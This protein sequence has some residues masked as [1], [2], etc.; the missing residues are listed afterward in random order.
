[1]AA[2][3]GTGAVGPGA[4]GPARPDWDRDGSDWPHRPASRFIE[5]GGLRWHVQVFGEDRDR[6]TVLLLHGTGAST[7][8]WRGL[9]PRLAEHL[10]VVAPDLPGHAFSAM[11]PGDG[12]SLPGMA[13]SVAALLAALGAAP[14]LVVGHSAGAAIGA[15]LILD[16]PGRGVRGLVA[17]NPAFLPFEGL[18]GRVFSPAARW[19]GR[20][21]GTP[22]LL[23]RAGALPQVLDGL[24]RGTGSSIG[25]DGRR[26]YGRLVAAPG[27]VAGALGMMARWDLAPLARDLPRLPCPLLAI[28][29][30][31]DRT[32]P[33]SEA[34]RV[35]ARIPGAS[36]ETLAGL[37][38]LAHEERPDL[39]AQRIT[40]FAIRVGVL[41]TRPAS[42]DSLD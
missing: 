1:V 16:S 19:L 37:G 4:R 33:P 39:V 17:L 12:L 29:G 20:M 42:S 3:R 15:R 41:P 2:D 30:A 18:P 24:L 40:A 7:H 26:L 5:A 34:H 10:R 9:A 28:V 32:V 13:A 23:A 6:P 38:H 21:P 36:V 31:L 11:P 27:H 8:S 25:E 22:A 35:A 14:A